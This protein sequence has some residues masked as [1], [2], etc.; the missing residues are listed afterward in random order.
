MGT[1]EGGAG[2]SSHHIGQGL[3]QPVEGGELITAEP[4]RGHLAQFVEALIVSIEWFEEGHRVGG[5]DQNWQP[6]FTGGN[7]H[8]GQARIIREYQL[9]RCVGD[10]EAKVL[11]YLQSAGTLIL[12]STKVSNEQLRWIAFM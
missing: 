5:V 7:E 8:L 10:V 6:N 11:P 3:H 4:P 12:G 2:R 9:P 1:D